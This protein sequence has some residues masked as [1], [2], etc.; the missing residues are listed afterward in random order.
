M[1]VIISS[2]LNPHSKS[3]ILAQEAL[4][5]AVRADIAARVL[6]LREHPLPLCDGEGSSSPASEGIARAL[7]EAT[8][9]LFATP[10][11]NYDVSAALK[12]VVEHVGCE[13]TGKAVG[14][15]CAA[16]GSRA[17]MAPLAFLNSL[18]LD[19]RSVVVPRFVFATAADFHAESLHSDD[20][21]TR[22]DELVATAHALGATLAGIAHQK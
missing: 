11:Y 6:D 17:A 3:R 7:R 1:I 8:S 4:A 13:L 22:I 10:I 16:G 18:M 14:I 9:V 19:F 5:A 21:R 20:L 2:S 15:L 12:N